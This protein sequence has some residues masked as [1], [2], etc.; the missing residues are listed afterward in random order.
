MERGSGG[1][2]FRD[3]ASGAEYLE[4]GV[5][6]AIGFDRIVRLQQHEVRAAAG[7]D[8]IAKAVFVPHQ[9]MMAVS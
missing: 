2:G 9:I 6:Q 5:A 1:R 8:A 7:R 3:Q 4:R